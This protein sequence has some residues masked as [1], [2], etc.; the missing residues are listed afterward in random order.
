MHSGR[1]GKSGSKRPLNRQ[2][3]GWVRYSDK[4][5]E[6]LIVKFAKENKT[7]SEIGMILRDVY[8]VPDIKAI[9]KKSITKILKEKDL[10][11]ELP[12]DLI[13]IMRKLIAVKQHVANNK[14]DMSAKRGYQL[15]EAKIKRLIKYYKRVG[16]IPVKWKYDVTKLKMYTE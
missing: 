13:A 15:T 10:T 3:P 16:R 7:S 9:T 5:I 2:V 14:Q 8:G 11:S 4:E 6:M 1:K 12:E